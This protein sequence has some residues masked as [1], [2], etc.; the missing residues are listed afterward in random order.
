MFNGSSLKRT[1]RRATKRAALRV[2]A[3]CVDELEMKAVKFGKEIVLSGAQKI[4]GE[5][6]KRLA[7]PGHNGDRSGDSMDES[8]E[9]DNGDMDD[10]CDAGDESFANANGM[11]RRDVREAEGATAMEAETAGSSDVETWQLINEEGDD[12]YNHNAHSPPPKSLWPRIKL[13]SGRRLRTVMDEYVHSETGAEDLELITMNLRN[14]ALD[15]TVEQYLKSYDNKNEPQD[16]RQLADQNYLHLSSDQQVLAALNLVN[17][18]EN[19]KEKK[20]ALKA[21]ATAVA[22]NANKEPYDPKNEVHQQLRLCRN[23]FDMFT[24]FFERKD[25][26]LQDVN[27]EGWCLTFVFRSLLFDPLLNIDGVRL[28]SGEV[29]SKSSSARRQQ[30]DTPTKKACGLKPDMYLRVRDEYDSEIFSHEHKA[31]VPGDQP[32][33]RLAGLGVIV[34][35]IMAITDELGLAH[36]VTLRGMREAETGAMIYFDLGK[37]ISPTHW[38]RRHKLPQSARTSMRL[39]MAIQ[40]TLEHIRWLDGKVDETLPAPSQ[41]HFHPTCPTPTKKKKKEAQNRVQW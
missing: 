32:K 17:T 13:P 15:E 5:T 18:A 19:K 36:V 9:E 27:S 35:S 39:R 31:P 33:G 40:S 30:T 3:A 26:P 25:N 29:G 4:V 28:I 34:E 21:L 7:S 16:W 1:F 38:E 12:E 20:A 23:M 2:T 22:A 14:F 41:P 11:V 6:K 10:D 24:S 8:E 37:L